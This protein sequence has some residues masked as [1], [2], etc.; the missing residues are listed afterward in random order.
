MTLRLTYLPIIAASLLFAQNMRAENATIISQNFDLL[1]AGTNETPSQTEENTIDPELTAGQEWKGKG[2]H[3]AGGALAIMQYEQSDWFGTETVQGYVQ[4]PYSD[5]RLDEGKFTVKFRA[6]SLDFESTTLRIEVYDPYTSNYVDYTQLTLTNEWQELSATLSHVGYG[7]HLAFMQIA[8]TDGNWLLDDFAVEQVYE[9]LMPPVIHF[10]KNVT[11]EQFTGYWNAVPMAT[12]YLVSAYSLDKD[13]N[14]V[15]LVK[16]EPTSE[17]EYT[18]SGTEKGVQYY[19]TVKSTNDRFTSVDAEPRA[20][21]VPLTSLDKPVALTADNVSTDGFTARWEPTFRAMAYIVTLK[22]SHIATGDEQFTVVSEDFAKCEGYDDYPDWASP[23]YGNLDDYTNMAGWTAPNGG[24]TLKGMFGL[25]NMWKQ[26]EDIY[27]SSPAIDLSAADGHFTVTVNVKGTPGQ[28]LNVT[29]GDVVESKTLAEEIEE[30]TFDFTNGTSTTTI[31]FEF[32]G[33]GYLFFDGITITQ[34]V[35]A[36]DSVTENVGTYDTG[37]PVTEYVF[38]NLNAT[39]GD[40]FLYTVT[41]WSY[42]LGEDGIWGP[43]VYSEPSDAIAVA[44]PGTTGID[45]SKFNNETSIRVVNGQ[46]AVI[47]PVAAELQLYSTEGIL[48]GSYQINPGE[49]RL[50]IAKK[51]LVIARIGNTVKKIIIL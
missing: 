44:I 50:D 32:D 39:P 15:Y 3:Q 29:C 8:A 18:V 4:T 30:F 28:K 10:A 41:A 45:D 34:P 47:S 42:S 2:L 19:Y 31:R 16:D 17:C 5:V 22:R 26:Y 37:E 27:L 38:S 36:G 35:K 40:T 43:N 25:D 11:H 46:I 1:T 14:P 21:N 20:V 7:N 48:I 12:S 9:T 33:D 13:G 23:F 6:R 24:A 51:G 49:T